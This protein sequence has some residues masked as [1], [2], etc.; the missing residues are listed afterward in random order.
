MVY[1]NNPQSVINGFYS[2]S[3]NVFLTVSV[4]VAMYGF[5][6]TFKLNISQNN[7]KNVSLMI[8]IFSFMLGVNNIVI[9]YKYINKLEKDKENLPIYV[10][11]PALKAHIYIKIFFVFLVAIILVLGLIRLKNRIFN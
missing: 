11:I 9:F 4:A 1:A 10:D 6:N 2:A 5:S 3:R 8:L 7:I